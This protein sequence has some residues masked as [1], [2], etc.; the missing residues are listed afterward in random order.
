MK[1]NLD[2]YKEDII[3]NELKENNN[4]IDLI[5]KCEE[6]DYDKVIED[7]L[8]LENFLIF[9]DIRKNIISWYPFQNRENI[10]EIGANFGEIT[11]KLCDEFD[12]VVSVEF[13]KYKGD[14]I[15][16]RHKN[17]NNL[18][19]IIGNLKDI[20]FNEKFDYITLVG[21]FEYAP[22]I[23]EGSNSYEQLLNYVSNLL[24]KD[25]KLL[26]AVDNKFGMRNWSVFNKDDYCLKTESVNS[27]KPLNKPQLFSKSTL[28][29]MFKNSNFK[30]YKF[31][32][33]LPD[34]RF[35]NVFF[36]DNFLP[37]ENNLHRNLSVFY[38]S[39][40]INF[41]ENAGFSEIIKENPKLFPFFANSYFVELGNSIDNSIKYVSFWNIRN[42]EYKLKTIIDGNKVYKMAENSDAISHIEQMKKNID[43]L[44]SNKIKTLDSYNGN[45]VVSEF[46]EKI[47][48]FD[49]VIIEKYKEFGID[50]VIDLINR[51]KKD[52]LYK[53]K[54]EDYTENIFNKLNIDCDDDLIKELHYTK[55]GIWD[56][57][58][59]NT[60]YID[61][62]LYVYDQEWI[63][64]DIPIEFILY[65]GIIL[66]DELKK[67]V[68][69]DEILEKLN[70]LKYK[71]LFNKLESIISKKI[72][73]NKINDFY[74]RNIENVRALIVNNSRLE[75]QNKNLILDL[76]NK[77]EYIEKIT[78][79]MSWK[80]T[81]PF[82]KITNVLKKRG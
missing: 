69:I 67:L 16:A 73:N 10:L 81:K 49:D 70:L 24:K 71:E 18:E 46:K 53:L 52:V 59:Q 51:F 61:N 68:N 82:R 38:D 55:E 28:E 6:D 39:E 56:L 20:K 25:G 19:V 27:S 30:N 5:N 14:A 45:I 60:F 9:S 80:I 3:F 12:R 33:T 58:F 21:C 57:N 64:E 78:N 2:F 47:K 1:L 74:L 72:I 76:K 11:G 34:Y 62:E 4:I 41:H 17:K 31:Y 37:K 35:P 43:I 42:K 8:N 40:V 36:T 44:V 77:N 22:L 75:E 54:I 79:S 7:N 29:E 63:M 66:F 26:I 65:R 13:S 23:F 48:S 50:F 32:Y 15:S